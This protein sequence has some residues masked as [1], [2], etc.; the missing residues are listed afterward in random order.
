MKFNFKAKTAEGDIREGVIEAT[1]SDAAASV[2]QKNSL[3]P[4][5]ITSEKENSDLAKIVLKYYDRVNDK[6]LVVFFRQLAILIEA[7]VPI[8]A[9]LTAISEQSSGKYLQKV[10]K[11]MINDVE[12]GVPF[13]AAMDRHRDVFSSL[14]INIIRAGETSGNLKKS[15][16]YVADNIEKNYQLLSRVR[17]AMIYPAIVMAVF[18]IIGFL[19]IS[20]I[21]PRLT[22]M[23]KDLNATVPWYTKIVIGVG[24]FMAAYWW[25]VAIVIMGFIG[26]MIYYIKTPDGKRE[27][28]IIKIKA[29]VFGPIFK[30]VYVARFAEN[31]AVLLVGGIP[32]I[33]ALTVV[34]S[35]INNSVYEKIVLQAA[36]QIK[37]GGNMSDVFS[38]N[39]LIPPVVSHMIKIGEESGQIDSVLNHI[40]RFY[41]Q[42]T[43]MAT[44]NLS[45]LIEPLLMIII[46]VAVGFMAVAILMPIYDIANQIK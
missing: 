30:G 33:R 4:I 8:I 14:S 43:E 10:I 28:D 13:S 44:K 22:Q 31:L 18:F 21:L 34:S 11:E 40:A 37:M 45:T 17:G 42:E 46:G 41:D 19:T 23:I 20:F 38:K 3:F 6:E 32:I 1:S 26:G 24:D 16:D 29:P 2:L 9:A 25:A 27:M 5:R 36:E 39:P 15:V 12:D 7:R 35:V